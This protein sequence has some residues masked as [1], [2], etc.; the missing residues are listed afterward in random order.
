MN[1]FTFSLRIIEHTKVARKH[2]YLHRNQSC[3]INRLKFVI[4]VEK[5]KVTNHQSRT[6]NV[7]QATQDSHE[8]YMGD[9][10]PTRTS[11]AAPGSGTAMCPA[12]T[13]SAAVRSKR[14]TS[15]SSGNHTILSLYQPFS[16]H[17]SIYCVVAGG[18]PKVMQP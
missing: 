6:L 7:A 9:F 11:G 4:L 1:N 12:P 3:L 13:P 15:S 2:S 8:S 17:S 18:Q 10:H 14:S 5:K 16:R